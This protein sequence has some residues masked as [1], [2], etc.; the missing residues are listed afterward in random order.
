MEFVAVFF[1]GS[2]FVGSFFFLLNLR[3]LEKCVLSCALRFHDNYAVG[4][5]VNE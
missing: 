5:F 2:V 3:L 4:N 1:S